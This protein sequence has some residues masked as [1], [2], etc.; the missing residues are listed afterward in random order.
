MPHG[1]MNDQVL[2]VVKHLAI[3]TNFGQFQRQSTFREALGLENEGKRSGG[4]QIM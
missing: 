3:K 4:R 2:P 1:A